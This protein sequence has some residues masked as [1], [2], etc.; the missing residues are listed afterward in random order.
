MFRPLGNLPFD[1]NGLLDSRHRLVATA[2]Q[3]V[4][5]IQATV[6]SIAITRA[7]GVV[8]QV[9]VGD[10]VYVGDVI[11]TD[12]D[13][14]V[15][16]AFA[17]GT[18]FDLSTSARMAV[19]E[20]ACKP[21]GGSSSAL[22][23]IARGAFT[24]IAGKVGKAGNLR[25]DTPFAAIQA[26]AGRG[27]SG[28]LALTALTLSL[29]EEIRAAPHDREW[30]DDDVI[31]LE[32]GSF[33]VTTKEANP[34]TFT[35]DNI[36][37]T[38][39]ISPSGSG[40]NVRVVTNSSARLAEL[41][42]FSQEALSTLTFGN[43]FIQQ[44]ERGLGDFASGGPG[45]ASPFI[46]TA[47][48]GGAAFEFANGPTTF[49]TSNNLGSSV[50]VFS[51]TNE[52]ILT[53]TV[54]Q[55]SPPPQTEPPPPAPLT[56]AAVT[57][58]SFTD[59]QVFDQFPTAT[60]TVGSGSPSGATLTYG[61]AGGGP[62]LSRSTFDVSKTNAYG[63]LYVDSATGAYAFVPNDGAINALTAPTTE[64]FILTVSDGTQSTSQPL[65][66][67]IAGANDTPVLALSRRRPTTTRRSLTS[68]TP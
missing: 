31:E 18:T 38:L 50:A 7:G 33:T 68:S 35:V 61:I 56:F 65:T 22:F 27:G 59:T 23:T 46:F 9:N 44:L 67:N 3:A 25:I 66:I 54:L 5:R 49:S 11:E 37:E 47:G 30:L 64:V 6:G 51:T 60:G 19:S 17:D 53:P 26:T 45:S 36:E 8:G 43:I 58:P 2:P 10:L 15:H 34:R 57:V 20:F 24:F 32:R 21:E 39:I 29:I 63:T 52:V 12:A 13:G 14:A 42:G 62:D 40:Y 1:D 4:G 41:A 48:T 55:S 16:V 28:F